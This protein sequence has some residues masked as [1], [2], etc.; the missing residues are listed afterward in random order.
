MGAETVIA[1]RLEDAREERAYDVRTDPTGKTDRNR[2]TE[3]DP[4]ELDGDIDN[5]RNQSDTGNGFTT[6]A[7]D[8]VRNERIRLGEGVVRAGDCSSRGDNHGCNTDQGQR[9]RLLRRY[10]GQGGCFGLLT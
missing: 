6:R 3:E 5:R 1:T 9:Q 8:E 4:V 10:R 7:R 2:G